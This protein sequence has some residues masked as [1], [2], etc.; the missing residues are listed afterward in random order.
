MP[1]INLGEEGRVLKRTARCRVSGLVVSR[2]SASSCS[3][4]SESTSGEQSGLPLV[5]WSPTLH[6][7]NKL[8]KTI[9]SCEKIRELVFGYPKQSQ[10]EPFVRY[11]Y[12][13]LISPRV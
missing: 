8:Q 1:N 13:L 12:P 6:G 4:E 11:T 9:F 2:A 5:I 7:E 10:V 3:R